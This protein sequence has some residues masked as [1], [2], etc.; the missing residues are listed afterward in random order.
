MDRK[1]KKNNLNP[2]K[3]MI[4]NLRKRIYGKSDAGP[5]LP[6]SDR[7]CVFCGSNSELKQYKDSYIC[8]ECLSGIF[9]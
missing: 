8:E 2:E 5:K 9:N 3:E 1:K 7:Y 4:R 6:F